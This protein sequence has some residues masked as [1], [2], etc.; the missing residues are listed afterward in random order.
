MRSAE[1]EQKRR[2]FIEQT[3][4]KIRNVPGYSNF[5]LETFCVIAKV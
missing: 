1:N 2:S 4:D 3:L 5:Y